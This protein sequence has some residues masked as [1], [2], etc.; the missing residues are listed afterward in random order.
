MLRPNANRQKTSGPI[1]KNI[2]NPG[3]PPHGREGQI[4]HTLKPDGPGPALTEQMPGIHRNISHDLPTTMDATFMTR[5]LRGLALAAM[6][7][8]A[9]GCGGSD[10]P[11]SGNNNTSKGSVSANVNG[12][13]WSATTV[14]STYQGGVLG[15][16]GAQISGAENKQINIS[17]L[18][19]GPGTYQL[20]LI[21]PLTVTYA[22]GSGT[23]VKTFVARSGSVKVDAISATSAKGSFSFEAQDQQGNGTR[24]VTEGTFDVKF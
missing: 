1:G 13:A 11:A 3:L 8:I 15:I 18:V 6:L 16:G 7:I 20:G 12:A 21:A 9:Q 4:A 14:Q 23:S 19:S 5:G 2:V 17:G 24:S 22:E 10:D